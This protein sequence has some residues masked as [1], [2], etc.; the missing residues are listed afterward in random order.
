MVAHQRPGVAGG[1]AFA[2]QPTQAVQKAVPVGVVDEDRLPVDPAGDHMLQRP[3]GIDSRLARHARVSIT[4]FSAD[5]INIL[6]NVPRMLRMVR[7]KVL[8]RRSQKL[9][10]GRGRVQR[11]VAKWLP[12]ARV[13]H[14]HPEVRSGVI[15]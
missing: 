8:K 9:N 14:P 2:E 5:A 10:L 1:P 4:A 7:M 15:A 6:M 12:P 11:L 3:R 13:C